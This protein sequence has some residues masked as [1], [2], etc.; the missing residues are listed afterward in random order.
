MIRNLLLAGVAACVVSTSAKADSVK[1][2]VTWQQLKNAVVGADGADTTGL[3]L[4]YWA[5]AVNREGTVCA[6]AYS[7]ADTGDQWLLSR[8]IAAAKAFTSNGLSQNGAPV[9]TGNLYRWVQPWI[10]TP[11]ASTSPQNS[12]LAAPLYGVAGNNPINAEAAY[13]GP[14]AKFGTS[15]DPMVG[16]RVGGTI[17]FGGGLA[18]Y[19]GSTV[20]GAIGV[21]GDTACADHSVAWRMRSNAAGWGLNMAPTGSPDKITLVNDPNSTT[22]GI[23]L[24]AR[25]AN[26]ANTQGAIIP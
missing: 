10:N 8:Q 9:A 19:N 11:P 1:C 23:M 24:H 5:V 22:N 6:V 2:P 14:Y 25:C 4:H 17:P 12:Y 16:E 15:N 20:V 26:D 7:G 21:S 13:K 3:N 18:L